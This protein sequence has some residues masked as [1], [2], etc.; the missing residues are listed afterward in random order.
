MHRRQEK[1]REGTADNRAYVSYN[2][3]K[4]IKADPALKQLPVIM[5]TTSCTR[6]DIS[7]SYEYGIASC[8]TKPDS[9]DGYKE[10]MRNFGQYWLS[11]SSLP[12]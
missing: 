9:L 4:A 3:A 7:R 1:R 6:A 12:L 11:V 10:L 8:I 5:F 2:P